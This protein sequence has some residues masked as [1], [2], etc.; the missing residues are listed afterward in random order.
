MESR[1]RIVPADGDVPADRVVKTDR[2]VKGAQW[3]MMPRSVPTDLEAERAILGAALLDRD[4]AVRV[5]T[6]LPAMFFSERH[7]E[8]V[9]AVGA[10]VSRHEPVDG[11]TLRA[12]QLRDGTWPADGHV[13]VARCLESASVG[14]TLESYITILREHAARRS[15]MRETRLAF[16]AAQRA[17]ESPN[18]V[19]GRLMAACLAVDVETTPEAIHSGEQ[20][21]REWGVV[22]DA[23]SFSSG[24]PI[25]DAFC[26]GLK[27][28]NLTILAGRPGLGKTTLALQIADH[29]VC[30]QQRPVLFLSL[31][32]TRG[33]ITER[34][35]S[36]MARMPASRL[37]GEG[38]ERTQEVLNRLA[39][40]GWYLADPTA[41]TLE[42]VQ[43]LIRRGVASHGV[44]LVVLDY[45]TKISLPK[46]ERH[47]LAVGE[48]VQGLR[49]AARSLGV[50]MLVLSQLNRSVEGREVPRPRLSDLRD[51]GMIEQEAGVVVYLWT[52]VD[53]DAHVDPLPV[54][55]T[56]AKCRWGQVGEREYLFQR[57]L[58]RFV[59]V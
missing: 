4:S 5:A 18:E 33:E 43:A 34:L 7:R 31:D 16:L 38:R 26:G 40:T 10:L 54:R 59:E 57:P 56:V 25:L 6:V 28:R 39:R 20:L 21:A 51:S 45:L 50:A 1:E 29:V 12:Q 11:I 46:R 2:G 37:R 52:R 55:L 42:Q 48:V 49:T 35:L 44:Q 58:A 14:T 9:R 22:D 41:P 36:G 8:M 13:M 15:L 19:V 3:P 24:I 47:E 17:E 30:E 27:T 32:M 53:G 23:P